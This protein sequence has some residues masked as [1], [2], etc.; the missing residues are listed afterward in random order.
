[1]SENSILL[2]ELVLLF[3]AVAWRWVW[4]VHQ[5]SDLPLYLFLAMAAVL[6]VSA[7]VSI[8]ARMLADRQSQ[9]MPQL[10]MREK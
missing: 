3:V 10:L 7:W 4:K 2:V 9:S 1:M 5:K 8:V 6:M